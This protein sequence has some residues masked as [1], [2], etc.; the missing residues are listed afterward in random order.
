MNGNINVQVIG[1][2]SQ[3]IELDQLLSSFKS[4]PYV[5]GA[6]IVISDEEL[7]I[8]AKY[9]ST[10]STRETDNDPKTDEIYMNI[11]VVIARTTLSQ[12]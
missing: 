12:M 7:E 10:N 9:T 8:P 3:S 5:N 2:S 11:L 6:H 1:E 4:K